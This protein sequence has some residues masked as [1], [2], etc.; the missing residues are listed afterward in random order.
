MAAGFT[1][2]RTE[3]THFARAQPAVSPQRSMTVCN[4]T[5]NKVRMPV[6]SAALTMEECRE[7][8]PLAGNRASA[9]DSMAAE[10]FTEVVATE[11]VATGSSIKSG[12]TK[13][14]DMEK[15]L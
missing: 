11:V 12:P 5:S 9:G 14:N 13:I 10:D 1:V 15:D 7:A 4:R 3:T 6:P 8:F 2:M